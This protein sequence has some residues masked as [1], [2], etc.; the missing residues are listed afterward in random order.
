[1]LMNVAIPQKAVPHAVQYVIVSAKEI[2]LWRP[3]SNPL[4]DE[5]CANDILAVKVPELLIELKH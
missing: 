1:M 2:I 4:L 5:V 3:P